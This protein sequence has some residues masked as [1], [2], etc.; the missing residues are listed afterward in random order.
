MELNPTFGAIGNGRGNPLGNPQNL[1]HGVTG[2]RTVADRPVDLSRLRGHRDPHP[3]EVR[4]FEQPWHRAAA[5]HWASGKMSLK[6][7]ATACD[8]SYESVK[9]LAKN[10]WFQE[11]VQLIMQENGAQDIMDLFK[12]ECQNSLLT[13]I[14]LRDDP[15]APAS[16][17]RQSAT[18][19]L[20]QCLG[21]P[22]QRVE[23]ETATVS[24]DPVAEVAKLEEENKR[25]RNDGSSE[26]RS[27]GPTDSMQTEPSQ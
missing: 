8:V 19:I 12:A 3:Q 14:E 2:P 13:I 25:L 16:V 7:I 20:H 11:T 1:V 22:T 23:M 5:Y 26:L 4:K 17:R 9:A 6:N 21:K 24:D 27:N 18:D 15:K 10:P